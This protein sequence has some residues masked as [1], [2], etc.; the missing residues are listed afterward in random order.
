MAES[1][2]SAIGARAHGRTPRGTPS[3]AQRWADARKSGDRSFDPGVACVNGHSCER[4]TNN[5]ICIECKRA[6]DNKYNAEHKDAHRAR[7]RRSAVARADAVRAYQ[8]DYYRANQ[9]I[10]KRRSR[11]WDLAHPEIVRR[12]ARGWYAKNAK[13]IRAKAAAKYA[14]NPEPRRAALRKWKRENKAAVREADSRRRAREMG[15]A[16]GDRKAYSSY[17]AWA[18]S[19]PAVRCYWCRKPTRPGRKTRHID[20]IIPLAKGGADSVANLCVACPACNLTKNA[21][22]P[23]E[24]AGQSEFSLA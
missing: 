13:R 8:R 5:G 16:I 18:R 9:D 4:W 11:E 12:R 23:L 22:M 24:F 2:R 10:A 17:V 3:I 15:A 21:K 1:K 14:V 7:S 6:R 20:H 19:A